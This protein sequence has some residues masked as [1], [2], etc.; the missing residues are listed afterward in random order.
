[1]IQVVLVFQEKVKSGRQATESCKTIMKVSELISVLSQFEPEAEIVLS[2]DSEGNE[3]AP[4]NEVSQCLYS[5]HGRGEVYNLNEKTEAGEGA[6]NAIVL[7]PLDGYSV[8]QWLRARQAR[9]HS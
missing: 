5:P 7:Y 4:V 2:S 3:F 9:T 8:K 1:M 6:I